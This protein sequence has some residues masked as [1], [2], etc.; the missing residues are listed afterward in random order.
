MLRE[1]EDRG[2]LQERADG[3]HNGDGGGNQAG[4]L[5]PQVIICA[6]VI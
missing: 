3:R 6:I 2:G 4:D 5:A 1:V